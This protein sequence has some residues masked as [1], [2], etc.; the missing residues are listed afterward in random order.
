ML[1]IVS[2][3]GSGM[4]GLAHEMLRSFVVV[5]QTLSLTQAQRRLNTTRQTIRRHIETLEAARGVKLFNVIDRRYTLT[6]GG[7]QAYD[8][9]LVVLRYIG[10]WSQRNERLV[11]GY[12]LTNH[13]DSE[14]PFYAQQH[15]LDSI[16]STGTVL[17]QKVFEKWALA[18]GQLASD[19]LQ[20][21]IEHT[22]LY[23]ENDRQWICAHVGHQSSFALWFGKLWAASAIGKPIADDPIPTSLSKRLEYAYVEAFRHGY[24]HYDHIYAFMTRAQSAEPVPV[25][26]Q[27][28]V[29]RCWFPDQTPA[30]AVLVHR[31]RAVSIQGFPE[32]G[33]PPMDAELEM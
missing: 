27:R 18:K 26:Y 21:V 29:L 19:E 12:F 4:P 30:I 3:A 15:S 28:L 25:S 9:A 8:E 31:T 24:I 5:A 7:K 20:S 22:A 1:N 10:A 17:V 23:R 33:L 6:A 32:N 14:T 11:S 2:D 16:W 13:M